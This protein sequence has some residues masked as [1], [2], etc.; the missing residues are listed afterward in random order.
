MVGGQEGRRGR[1]RLRGRGQLTEAGKHAEAEA[2]FA[3][4]A[5][6]GTSG[7]RILA[8]LRE[9]AE[10]ARPIPKAAVKAYDALASR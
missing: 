2:A 6:D 5:D 4:I 10:L 3:K 8:R 1:R 9:A 7:Y